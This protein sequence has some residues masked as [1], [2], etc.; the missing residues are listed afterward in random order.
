MNAA[1]SKGGMTL[2]EAQA[3]G[4]ERGSTAATLDSLG[5]AGVT[6]MVRDLL[7]F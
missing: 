1:G 7:G 2:A 6:K 3:Q 5:T 4:L